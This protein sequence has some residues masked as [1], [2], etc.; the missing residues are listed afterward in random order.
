MGRRLHTLRGTVRRG[1]GLQPGESYLRATGTGSAPLGCAQS[2][3]LLGLGSVSAID[4]A[5]PAV[6][7]H[8][9]D[10]HRLPSRSANRLSIRCRQSGRVPGGQAGREPLSLVFQCESTLRAPLQLPALLV[11]VALWREQSHQQRK[12]ERGQQQYR[13]AH[14]FDI[15]KRPAQ[16]VQR[17]AQIPGQK[18]ISWWVV[19]RAIGPPRLLS[20]KLTE[21]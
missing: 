7:S 18:L 14:V 6:L 21:N 15:R 11:G 3:S 8:A 10:G 19:G 1:S 2:I 12:S 5:P 9:G 4:C 13:F 16:G 20:K 17:A